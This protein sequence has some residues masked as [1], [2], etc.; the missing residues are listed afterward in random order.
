MSDTDR[1][2]NLQPGDPTTS[3]NGTGILRPAPTVS[4]AMPPATEP[5]HDLQVLLRR[6]LTHFAF[7]GLCAVSVFAVIL[8]PFYIQLEDWH[9]LIAVWFL[10]GLTGGSTL[11]LRSRLRISL[12]TLASTNPSNR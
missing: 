2:A 4:L 7:I 1:P 5:S 6:R 12:R 10:V 9:Y 3:Y 11:L 8:T